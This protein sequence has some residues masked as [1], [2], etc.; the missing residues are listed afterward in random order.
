M[1]SRNINIFEILNKK[2]EGLELNENEIE[3]FVK[4]ASKETNS[5]INDSQIGRMKIKEKLFSN[6][7][8]N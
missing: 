3:W 7:K 6:K 2:S 8:Q 4:E 5:A 1:A